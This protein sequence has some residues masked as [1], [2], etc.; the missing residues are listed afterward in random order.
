MSIR[1]LYASET[2]NAEQL[3]YELAD[4]LA[5]H[6]STAVPERLNDVMVDQ[7]E[8]G[9]TL[10]V[11]TST[12]GEGSVPYDAE[13][14]WE[15]LSSVD[16]PPLEG[17]GFSV[18]ALG[19]S[20][21][22]DFCQAGKDIDSRL[23]ELGGERI[24]P[25][26]TCDVDFE[27]PARTWIAGVVRDLFDLPGDDACPVGVAT[28]TPRV[29]VAAGRHTARVVRIDRLTDERAAKDVWS[30]ALEVD[31]EV[32]R[33]QPG[34]SVEVIPRNDP[35]TVD[36]LLGVLGIDVASAEASGLRARLLDE[37]EIATPN[38]EM[39]DALAV[40]THDAE[41]SSLLSGQDRSALAA[42]LYDRDVA[43]LVALADARPFSADELLGVLRPIMAR[44]YSISSSPSVTADRLELT[45]AALRHC[46]RGRDRVG[47]SS[48]YLT[49]R[50]DIGSAVQIVHVPNERFRLPSEDVPIIMVGPG[51]GVAPFRAFLLERESRGSTAPNWL[52]FGSRNHDLDFLYDEELLAFHTRG[53]LTRLDL[54]FSRDA[55]SKVYVQDRMRENGAELFAW[56][57]EGAALY[58]CGDADR[59]ARDVHLALTAIVAEHGGF[60]IAD[61]ERY[62]QT[63]SREGR[64]LRDVY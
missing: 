16:V 30:I 31:P 23:E 20:D 3:A 44:S 6:G 41:L 9:S 61:A 25:L 50:V 42:F 26:A 18:L 33:Y 43:D 63:L 52:F 54:A 5:E 7:L 36:A 24:F 19:D 27:V 53:V 46:T 51:T 2:G 57:E 39:L 15:N 1:I 29:D 14:F 10:L 64:Y 48:T 35:N 11:V 12:T 49:D 38:R 45:V 40:R 60:D 13:T 58:I 56:L 4:A 47:V 28:A 37:Y 17:V 8:D 22:L 55:A 62:M 34:D 21:Y 32:M 59:M